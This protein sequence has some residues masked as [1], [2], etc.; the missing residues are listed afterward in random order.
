MSRPTF[1]PLSAAKAGQRVRLTHV[2][3]DSDDLPAV[4]CVGT[5]TT[6]DPFLYV[7][8]WDDPLRAAATVFTTDGTWE[9]G[10]A[11]GAVLVE[12]PCNQQ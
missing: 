3:Q 2:Y 12:E 10:D 5:I 7:V 9:Y 1:H 6:V 8:R 4:A 11:F